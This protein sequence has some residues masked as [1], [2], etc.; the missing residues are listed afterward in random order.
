MISPGSAS[1]NW[2]VSPWPAQVLLQRLAGVDRVPVVAQRDVEGEHRPARGAG[3]REA[4]GE[5]DLLE[6]S[7]G[8]AGRTGRGS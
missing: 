4:Q 2:A 3:G 6:V 8:G 7:P 5:D 1:P